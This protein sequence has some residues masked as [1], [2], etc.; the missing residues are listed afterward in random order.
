MPAMP[1][2]IVISNMPSSG[3]VQENDLFMMQRGTSPG[4]YLKSTA[5]QIADFVAT[6]LPAL[7]SQVYVQD[8]E[9]TV[10]VGVNFIWVQTGLGDGT[11]FTVFAGI[12]IS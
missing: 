1:N 6:N 8:D 9:P 12:G 11:D 2:T 4:Q 7:A 10:P 5:Q 3:P